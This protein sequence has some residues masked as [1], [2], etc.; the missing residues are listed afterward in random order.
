VCA[1]ICDSKARAWIA[2]VIGH[3]GHHG[4]GKCNQ[5]GI[6]INSRVVYSTK[7]GELRSDDGFR[8]RTDTDHI[9]FPYPYGLEMA[10]IKMVSQ[11]P[12]CPMH[13]VYLGVLRSMGALWMNP[14]RK[15]L[16]VFF[17]VKNWKATQARQFL[18][19]S[20]PI[21]LKKILNEEYYEHFLL[22]SVAIRILSCKV[23]VQDDTCIDHAD[24]M[25]RKF[26]E[27]Y[28][29]LY[30][31][32]VVIDHL[33]GVDLCRGKTTRGNGS[34]ECVDCGISVHEKCA[35]LPP[36]T[37]SSIAQGHSS[38]KC[39][40]CKKKEF[41]A[42]RASICGESYTLGSLH[43]RL[44]DL[45]SLVTQKFEDLLKELREE[46]VALRNRQCELEE[47]NVQHERRILALEEQ[48]FALSS[49]ADYRMQ[50]ENLASVEVQN[51]PN[52]LLRENNVELAAEVFNS[53]LDV[54]VALSEIENAHV[55]KIGSE[56]K[57]NMLVV[58]LKSEGVKTKIIN[59]RREKNRSNNYGGI[60]LS[61]VK[62]FVNERLTK[63]R[64]EMLSMARERGR[65]LDFKFVWVDN[66]V[67]KMR[68]R[69]G[70]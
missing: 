4:C 69:E 45:S 8:Q 18:L 54:D 24:T 16:I 61:G 64:R 3:T 6:T 23:F 46:N 25:L 47:K 41:S 5:V 53:A 15:D 52:E 38:Y 59:A 13:L 2:G 32:E 63:R 60:F 14:K 33:S 44:E 36:P 10:N 22:L 51:I 19:Y 48:V 28:P 40:E 65:K 35:N 17:F 11:L 62:I 29:K 12:L 1:F 30:G 42:K 37:L 31:A 7:C 57:K 55:M 56:R 67:V 49:E 26:V 39:S 20:G 21:V 43:N 27:D 9:K 50:R 58:K 68:K 66:G 34:L 70:E